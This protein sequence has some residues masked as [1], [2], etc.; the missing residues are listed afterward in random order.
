M[1]EPAINNRS[2]MQQVLFIYQWIE[3]P[4]GPRIAARSKPAHPGAYK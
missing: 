2:R 1:A 4:A 3:D